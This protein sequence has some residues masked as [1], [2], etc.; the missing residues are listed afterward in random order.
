M[1]RI[2][3]EEAAKLTEPHLNDGTYNPST[4]TSQGYVVKPSEKAVVNQSNNKDGIPFPVSVFVIFIIVMVL[5]SCSTI[6]LRS[7]FEA[8]VPKIGNRTKKPIR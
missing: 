8:L 2:K 5:L 3:K 1:Q 4:E 6:G 7:L